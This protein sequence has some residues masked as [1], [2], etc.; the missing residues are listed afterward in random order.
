MNKNLILLV[1]G[2]VLT[3]VFIFAAAPIFE[4][5]Y[6]EREFSNEMDMDNL[7]FTVALISSGIAWA[8]AAVFYYVVN[9][10]RF[11]RWYHWLITL[12][13]AMLAAAIANYVMA[14]GIFADNGFDF[15]AQLF[16]F[17]VIDFILTG[18]VFI[19]ASFAI[20]W[21][22]SNCRHTPWPE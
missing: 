11:S 12:L 10:V 16:S 22:S 17:S 4:A 19:L 20:R 15:G 21:W 8:L 18:V 7:Y 6:Y 1:T 13:V 14:D 3:L 5:L 2:I 9:S